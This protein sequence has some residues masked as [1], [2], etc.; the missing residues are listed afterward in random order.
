[1]IISLTRAQIIKK[2]KCRNTIIQFIIFPKI[3][4]DESRIKKYEDQ[5]KGNEN[6]NELVLFHY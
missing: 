6:I 3:D 1:M 4:N 5:R 2:N